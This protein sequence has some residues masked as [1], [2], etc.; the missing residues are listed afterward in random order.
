MTQ[1]KFQSFPK[2]RIATIDIGVASRMRHHVSALI[3]TDV[4]SIREKIKNQNKESKFS[5]TAWLIKTI[6]LTI[7]EHE[8]VA[9]YSKG[10][11][12]VAIFQDVNV[13]IL[14]EKEINGR[15]I[16]L[17]LVIERANEKSVESI[18]VQISDAKNKELTEEDIVLQ[19][20]S[21]RMER[22]YYVLPGFMRRLFWKYLLSH[23]VLAYSKMGNV[24]ITSVGMLGNVNGW[25][26]P[27]SVHPVCFG[28]GSIIKK[29]VVV[30]NKIEI[31]EILNMTIL[32][33]H[34]VIDGGP[35]V[36]FI[37]D[38]SENISKGN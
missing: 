20:K 21:K 31:R 33:D 37:S 28:I 23:P 5:F 22:V 15:R 26:I 9:A 16:P 19:K 35:M 1:Y 24:G 17:P 3:E 36:R 12:G 11:R 27:S 4:T 38:L 10:K 8:L 2:S 30:D 18:F 13:S 29:P 25:F 6:S 14:V 7:K 34:N 32:L